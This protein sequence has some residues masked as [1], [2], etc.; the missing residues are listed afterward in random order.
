[1]E[2]SPVILQKIEE[3]R[4]RIRE[5]DAAKAVY[6]AEYE[7][8]RQGDVIA[9][10]ALEETAL[11][12]GLDVPADPAVIQSDERIQKRIRIGRGKKPPSQNS[13]RGQ[14]IS[15]KWKMILIE[16][17]K[18]YPHEFAAAEVA[19]M[20]RGL[21]FEVKDNT[22]RT[23]LIAYTGGGYLDRMANGKYRATEV[24]AREVDWPLGSRIRSWGGTG[25]VDLFP[26][27][28]RT[29]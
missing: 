25:T 7:Q 22:C 20:A 18:N 14:G 3:R 13:R 4:Q 23:Q 24:C 5:R 29:K 11:A 6:L 15:P 10:K 17:V 28:A 27:V 2:D 16:M 1:M 26:S 9:L 19:R 12:M 8:A 21:G